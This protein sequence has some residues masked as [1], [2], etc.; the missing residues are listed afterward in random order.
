MPP[1]A[2]LICAHI[3]RLSDRMQ[4]A[5]V[6]DSLAWR[7]RDGELLPLL[8]V[9]GDGNY[10]QFC[11]GFEIGYPPG[12]AVQ[13]ADVQLTPG[14]QIVLATDGILALTEQELIEALAGHDDP[15]AAVSALLSAV[16]GQENPSQDNA[17]V[18]VV[19]IDKGNA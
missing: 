6:G 19:A 14:D 9:Q 11:V 17:T 1:A 7:F 8:S 15:A 4:I 13:V 10:V 2:T 3:D 18:L 16:E 12:S 5:G